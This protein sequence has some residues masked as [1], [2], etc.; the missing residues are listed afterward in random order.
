MKME[1][2]S[3]AFAYSKL[4]NWCLSFSIKKNIVSII[5]DL[6]RGTLFACT[7]I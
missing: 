6:K 5:Q 1:C 4:V 7:N 2:L 3:Y